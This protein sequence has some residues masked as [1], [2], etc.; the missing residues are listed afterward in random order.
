MELIRT[1]NAVVETGSF[2]QAAKRCQISKAL[3]SKYVKALE[4]RL[5]TQL[6]YRTTR[7]LTVTEAGR[8]YHE[9]SGE[10]LV[11]LDNLEN[12]VRDIHTQPKGKLRITMPHAFGKKYVMPD[13][14]AFMK[15]YP[16]IDC[17]VYLGERYVDLINEGFDLG[18]RVGRLD[19]SS[20]LSRKILDSE[21]M[22]CASPSYLKE[23]GVPASAEALAK[24]ALVLDT[25]RRASSDWPLEKNGKTFRVS[26]KSA[27]L[28]SN[29]PEAVRDA[30]VDGLGIGLCPEFSVRDLL[31]SGHL[32]RVLDDFFIDR[33]GVHIIYPPNRYVSGKVRTF[34]DFVVPRIQARWNA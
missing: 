19:D 23:A 15:A 28:I 33:G 26:T 8:A 2:T 14:L 20:L 31:V 22:L 7:R 27:R 11:E 24:H 3:V 9:R 34:I 29:S 18:I 30:L 32:V 21:L 25:N 13:V 16:E 1:Y 4:Q 17:E 5:D 12:S 10:L 6:L